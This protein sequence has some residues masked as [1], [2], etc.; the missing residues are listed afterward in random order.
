MPL[1]ALGGPI[2]HWSHADFTKGLISFGGN[3]T[4][5]VS[6]GLI[7]QSVRCSKEPDSANCGERG[8][9]SGLAVAILIAPLLDAAVLGWEEVPVD[10]YT[11]GG[12]RRL[13]AQGPARIGWTV[14]PTW[15]V[16][17]RGAFQIGVSGSF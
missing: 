12:G 8:F 3:A 11:G 14:A 4:F 17:P 16:G 5:L 13:G 10:M 1:Y 2:V 15:N 6:G 9:F 7:G